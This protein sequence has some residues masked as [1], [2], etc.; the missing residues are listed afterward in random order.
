MGTKVRWWRR[1]R[2]AT[3]PVE[4]TPQAPADVSAEPESPPEPDAVAPVDRRWV[5][6]YA[7]V[8]VRA[9]IFDVHEL[10][11][12]VSAAAVRRIPDP[13]LADEVA[14]ESLAAELTAWQ[15]ESERWLGR[16]DPERLD[17]ALD[18]LRRKGLGVHAAAAE[19]EDIAAAQR[20]AGT[21]VGSVGYNLAGVAGALRDNV[22]PLV[23]LDRSGN[24]ASRSGELTAL[25]QDALAD[26]GLLA[27]TDGRD[28]ELVVP[29]TWRRRPR[30]LTGGAAEASVEASSQHEE[31]R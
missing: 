24:P 1:R 11:Q 30:S 18:R 6:R 13:E 29:M 10:R 27:S 22:L 4:P 17:A 8:Q 31:D 26:E 9:G 20:L 12:L 3:G 19:A 16:T 23:L 21:S 25:V 5:R 14:R 15:A 28:G 2:A 7:R